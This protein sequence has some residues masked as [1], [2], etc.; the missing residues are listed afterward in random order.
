MIKEADNV[1]SPSPCNNNN[2]PNSAKIPV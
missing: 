1:N 2:P